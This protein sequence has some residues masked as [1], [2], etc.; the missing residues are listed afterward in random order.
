MIVY[1]CTE[2][3][4]EKK[5]SLQ[6]VCD[7][8]SDIANNLFRYTNQDYPGNHATSVP[9]T[10]PINIIA[11]VM[12][13]V[14]EKRYE[15]VFRDIK[16][17]PKFN[18]NSSIF[19]NADSVAFKRAISNI[20]NNAVDAIEDRTGEVS[21]SI[22]KIDEKV[23]II[24]EDNGKGMPEPV[25]ERILNRTPVTFDKANGHG[26]GYTQIHDM[27]RENEGRLQIQSKRNTG[28]KITLIF[29]EA[30]NIDQ[31]QTG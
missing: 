3:S 22:N 21:I 7:R 2:L 14:A 12:E 15:Y 25:R 9:N 31:K 30:L 17:T 29:Y 24:I 6:Q 16:F 26:I 23:Q 19:I 20:I 10:Q 18:T 27:L 28:T 4:D 13:I 5:T 1:S 8:I 11:D